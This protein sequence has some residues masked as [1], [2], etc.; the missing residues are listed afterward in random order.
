MNLKGLSFDNI[1]P[2]QV[3]LRYFQTAP[4]LGMLAALVLLGYPEALSSRWQ[5]AL[6][7]FTHLLTLGFGA[8]LMIG[9]LFQVMPVVTGQILPQSRWFAALVRWT[10]V[11]GTLLLAGG[12]LSGIALL[13]LFASLL[14]LASLI[15]FLGAFGWALIQVRPAGDSAFCLRLAALSLLVTGLIG[16][17]QLSYH[18]WP[19]GGLYH[20]A[21][22]NLHAAWGGFGWSLGLIIAV[23][24]QVIPMFHVTPSFPRW[25]ARILAPLLF[26][27]L[28]LLSLGVGP[29]LHTTA[30]IG[31]ALAAAVFAVIALKVLDR[32]KRKLVDWTVQFWR[33]GLA[34]LLVT[35]AVIPLYLFTESASLT[36]ALEL[37]IGLGFGLGFIVSIMVGM[38]QKIVP[39]LVYMHLQRN[40]VSNPAAM[41]SLP[42]MKTIIS[43]DQSRKQFYLHSL[44]LALLYVAIVFPVLRPVAA[45]VLLADFGWLAF[46]LRHAAGCYQSALKVIDTTAPVAPT[47]PTAPTAQSAP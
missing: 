45:L 7:A 32:R 40:C 26:S 18:Y 29:L 42:T 5:P 33:L 11:C 37:F 43:S 9:A 35:A 31:I 1:P 24:I 46:T 22:T 4:L 39:F 13:H 8:T 30:I 10:L 27:L 23:A 2:L 17:L 3:P 14:L 20:P 47:A 34:H 16:A 41:M 28:I 19:E 36:G 21:R 12:F 44:A 38:L 15:T 25:V 6:L